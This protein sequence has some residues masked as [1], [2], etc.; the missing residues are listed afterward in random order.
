M[1]NVALLSGGA[2]F[3]VMPVLAQADY[4]GAD[5][6]D[7]LQGILTGNIGLTIGLAILVLGLITLITGKASAG[8]VM[9]IGGALITLSPGIFN[10]VRTM[11]YGVVSQFA[12]GNTTTV[13]S[14]VGY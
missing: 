7:T 8:L 12:N 11:V 1:K 9:I 5:A 2:M 3:F 4:A 13:D 6:L 10:G 14:S